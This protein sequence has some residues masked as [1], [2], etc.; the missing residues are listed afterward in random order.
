MSGPIVRAVARNNLSDVTV[1]ECGIAL[2]WSVGAHWMYSAARELGT[3]FA[4]AQANA[5]FNDECVPLGQ[6]ARARLTQRG[7]A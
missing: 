5:R 4:T 1:E 7:Q 6:P 3:P 2:R